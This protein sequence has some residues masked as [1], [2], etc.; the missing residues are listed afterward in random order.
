MRKRRLE[1]LYESTDAPDLPVVREPPSEACANAFADLLLEREEWLMGRILAFA[2]EHEYTRYTSTLLEAWRASIDGLSAPLAEMLRTYRSV[3]EIPVEF[4]AGAHPGS[5]FGIHEARLHRERGINLALFLGLF[6]YYR[7]AYQDLVAAAPIEDA[8]DRAALVYF[9]DRYFD[10]VEVGFCDEWARLSEAD[11]LAELQSRN[12]ALVN[13]KNKYL[14]IFESLDGPV[15]FLDGERHIENMNAAA[16][17]AFGGAKH[18]GQMYYGSASAY[19][20]QQTLTDLLGDEPEIRRIECTLDTVDGPRDFVLHGRPMLDVSEKF[21]GEV[22]ILSDVT[23][24]REATRALH[25][26]NADLQ[27]ATRT[28]R[29]ANEAKSRFLAVMSHEIRT[30]MNA[31]AGMLQLLSSTELNPAQSHYVSSAQRASDVLLRVID[32]VLDFSRIEAG[33]LELEARDFE[34]S[35]VLASVVR[36]NTLAAE[37]KGLELLIDTPPTIPRS[38]VGDAIRLEQILVN[39]V[40]NAIKFTPEGSV[41]VSFEPLE[42]RDDST[43]LRVAVTDTGIGVDPD[44][45]ERL[46]EPFTQADASTTRTHGGSGLGLSICAQLISLMGGEL[47]VESEPGRGARFWFDVELGLQPGAASP[48]DASLLVGVG[49]AIALPEGRAAD[50]VARHARQ[51]GANV[52]RTCGGAGKTPQADILVADRDAVAQIIATGGAPPGHCMVVGAERERTTLARWVREGRVAAYVVQ[53]VTGSTLL[54]AMMTTLGEARVMAKAGTPPQTPRVGLEGATLLVVDDN[55]LNREVVREMLRRGGAGVLLASD[56][57]EAVEAVARHSPDA[58]LMDVHMPVMDGLEAT[59]AIRAT[60]DYDDLPILAVTADSL[61]E[62]RQ[63]CLDAGMN[64]V[65]TKPLR[66]RDLYA[67]VSRWLPV[68]DAPPAEVT[69]DPPLGLVRHH[70]EPIVDV[71]RGLD[72]FSGDERLFRTM[73]TRFGDEYHDAAEQVGALLDRDDWDAAHLV[74][75]ALKGTSATL[76]AMRTWEASGNL[77]AAI[78]ARRPRI[79]IEDLRIVFARELEALVRAIR[80]LD[81]DDRRRR[82]T[83]SLAAVG[84]PDQARDAISRIRAKLDASRFVSSDDVVELRRSTAGQCDAGRL[85]EFERALAALDIP[86]CREL[87][88]DLTDAVGTS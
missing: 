6:I 9:V 52:H 39:L 86:H 38:L 7:Q 84:T 36:L 57:R 30:P 77:D 45:I 2:R 16:F 63:V 35:D 85:D 80:E 15:I 71:T 31:V 76:A 54:D 28:A 21:L 73:L 25:R 50:I 18:P 51:L 75:H 33:K 82:G 40:S 23:E 72:H 34:L 49:V 69:D 5:Q 74:A 66:R 10:L 79:E 81:E 87:L 53:P 29:A 17:E 13:E 8:D 78:R 59:K 4:D 19:A 27:E 3:P 88:D 55:E 22:L 37:N 61:E 62:A 14:T 67:S 20:L 32:D 46:L 48:A 44:T 64:D 70:L 41:T 56:G 42:T 1:S 68:A 26:A 24:E 11:K 83:A 65:L 58:V 47:A 60:G 12:R 43:R